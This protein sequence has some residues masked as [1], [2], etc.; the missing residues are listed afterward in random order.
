MGIKIKAQDLLSLDDPIPYADNDTPVQRGDKR[1]RV[2]IDGFNELAGQYGV[3]LAPMHSIDGNGEISFSS[4]LD[5]YGASASWPQPL[6][7]LLAEHD[8]EYRTGTFPITVRKGG[9]IAWGTVNH[10]ELERVLSELGI[11]QKSGPT[12]MAHRSSNMKIRI[13]AQEI[14]P[15]D[16]LDMDE[17]SFEE[18]DSDEGGGK[19]PTKDDVLEWFLDN[20]KPSDEE[21]HMWAEDMGFAAED[22]EEVI[23]SC[24]GEYA[25]KLDE[26]DG[27]GEEDEE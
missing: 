5:S 19:A 7:D 17:I 4:K 26:E 1:E 6:V 12:A 16:D 10:F 25:K 23:Y 3:E 21:V 9:S 14:I 11:I 27:G 15:M 22:V 24:V 18:P 2:L 20:P 13:K 8:F